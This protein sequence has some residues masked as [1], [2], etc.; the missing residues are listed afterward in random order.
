LTRYASIVALGAALSCA[1]P[2]VAQADRSGG[3]PELRTARKCPNFV[4]YRGKSYDGS[5]FHYPARRVRR[6]GRVSC[7]RVRYMLRG[8]Y[9]YDRGRVIEHS[10]GRPTVAYRGGWRC[11]NGAGGAACRNVKHPRWRISATVDYA[12]G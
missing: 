5:R 8:T 7:K 2:L 6:T 4:V 12:D 1:L 9:Y 11:G 3:D 10:V